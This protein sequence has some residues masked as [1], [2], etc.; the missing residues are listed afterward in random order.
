MK[1]NTPAPWSWSASLLLAALAVAM[2]A[3][4]QTGNETAPGIWRCG[5]SYGD[6][7]CAGGRAVA[8]DDRR[9][10][11]QQ[12]DADASARR[13]QTAADRLEQDRLRLERTSARQA[14]LITR[15]LP[16]V[17]ASPPVTPKVKVKASSKKKRV[18]SDHF[19]AQGPGTGPKK[20]Q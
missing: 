3:I 17:V 15:P 2:P 11:S 7:P 19:I 4:A 16:S 5:N 14:V 1:K 8:L 10:A 20:K 12:R 18:A 9:D 6:Q 13:A